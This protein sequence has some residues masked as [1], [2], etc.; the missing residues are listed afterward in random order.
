MCVSAWMCEPGRGEGGGGEG[1]GTQGDAMTEHWPCRC[2]EPHA[3]VE[4][5]PRSSQSSVRSIVSNDPSDQDM[6]AR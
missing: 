5:Q 6:G 4:K 1:A 3:P 2:T